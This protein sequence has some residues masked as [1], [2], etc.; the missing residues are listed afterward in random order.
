MAFDFDK[1]R[2]TVTG[3]GQQALA[4]RRRLLIHQDSIP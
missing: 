2:K 3:A 1:L 4:K